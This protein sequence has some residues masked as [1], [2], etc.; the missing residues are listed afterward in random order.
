MM[1]ILK[2]PQYRP[3]PVEHQVVIL[4]TVLNKHLLDISVDRVSTFEK[5]FL[6]FVDNNYPD[7]IEDIRATRD[8]T[9]ENI[10]RIES[11]IAEFKKGW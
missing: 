6:Q 5:E 10:K 1:E 9:E 2:Q 4:Y 3:V 11:A 8:L 7:I